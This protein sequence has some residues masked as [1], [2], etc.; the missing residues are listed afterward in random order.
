M[1]TQHLRNYIDGRWVEG[2][3]G[4]AFD[5]TDPANGEVLATVTR[6]NTADLDRPAHAHRAGDEQ[7][8]GDDERA[9]LD[10]AQLAEAEHAERMAAQV[11]PGPGGGLGEGDDEEQGAGVEEM[12]GKVRHN[13]R[14]QQ[15]QANLP[16]GS[17][18]PVVEIRGSGQ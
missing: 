12:V 5:D 16:G 14:V 18:V 8:S 1:A 15:L 4:E 11:E 2:S 6:S 9:D 10:P 3:S 17:S 7:Q 13:A